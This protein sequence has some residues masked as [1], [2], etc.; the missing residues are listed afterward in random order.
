MGAPGSNKTM[1]RLFRLLAVILLS[2]LLLSA[3]LNRGS[4]TGTVTDN[5][6]AVIPNVKLTIRN[7]AT[8]AVY[9]AAANE[10]GQYNAPNLP[11]GTYTV[12]FEAPS[13]KK[14]E[15]NDVE[16][17]VTQVLRVDATM[18]VGAVT[19][20]VSISAETPRLQTD[21]PEVGTSLT[22]KQLLDLPLTFAGARIAENF[23]YL[24]TPGVSGNTWTSN[25]N[26]S[27]SFS[28]ESLLD[29]ATVTTYLAGHFS[30]SS[31]SVE[32]LQ[33]MKI[34]TSGMSAEFGR[35][36]AGV[37]NYVM[38]SG[39]N[40]IH[41][42]AYG[43]LRNEALNANTAVNKFNNRPRGLD[44]RQNYAFSGGAPIYIPKIYNGTNKTFFYT[45]F[46][47]YRE[48]IGGFGSPSTTA[49]Q[50]E[51]LDGDFSRLLGP[52]IGQT[53]ALGRPVL[54]GAIYD[55]LTF[56][57]LDNGRWIGDMFPGNRIPTTRF[58]QVSQRLNTLL[59]S[60]YL[61]TVRNPDGTIPL[62][63]N[64]VRPA[65]NTPEFDQ[66]QFSTKIDQN[67]S[68]TQKLS[69]SFSYNKR[70]RLLLDQTRLW[71][72]D[73]PFGGVLTS[74]RRQTIKS[75]LVRLSH[76]WNVTQRLLNTFTV[77]YNRMAN[78][79]IG[80]Y[81]D[82]NGA[83][84][85]GI[86]NL[87]T[88]GFP[89]IDWSGGPFVGLTNIGDPQNDFQVYI[90]FGLINTVSFSKG[91]H[92]MK[93]GV[94]LRRN[95][96][97]TRPTQGGGFTFAARG[98]AIP[99]ETFSGNQTGYAFA[100]YLLGI[101]DSA[102]LSDPVGLGGR[103]VYGGLFFQDD[104]KVSSRLTLNLG[105]RWE[106][107]PPFTE[108]ADRLS[109]WNPN[110][111]D[112]ATG[113]LGAYDFAGNCSVCTGKNYFGVKSYRDFGPR[114][115][116]AYR[117]M[118][119]WTLRGAY[120]I[121]YEGDLFNGFSGTPLGKA[122]SVQAGGAYALLPDS[123]TPWAG[124]FNWDN[125]FPTRSY[126]PPSY[127]VSYGD[128]NR[129]G[130]IDPNYGRSPYTQQWNFNIQRE[131]VRNLVLDVG[132]VGNKATGIRAGQLALINQL[133]PK[134][135]QQF[136]RNL[137]NAIRS[138]EDAAANGVPYPYPGYQGT[139]AG[140]LRPYPQLP[141][142]QTVQNYGAPLGF[143]TYHSLQVTVNRQFA[144]G[145]TAYTN[146][147]WSKNLTNVQSSQVND[148]PGRPLD[149]YNLKLEKALSDDDQPHLF[150]AYISYD[151]PVGHGKWLLGNSPR[152]VN[153]ILGGWSISGIFNYFSGT[154]LGFTGSSPLSGGWNGAVNRANVSPGNLRNPN[155]DKDAFQ[156]SPV[157][158]P[159]NTFLNTALF[160]DPAPL[161][162]GNAA[163]R[164]GQLR[165]FA[166]RN[167]DFGLQKNTKLGERF[168]FQL[169]AEF[170]NAFNR[171][172]LGGIQT[173]VTNP[174]FG[175][176]T[177]ISGNRQIQLGTRLDF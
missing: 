152:V 64:A 76:D 80:N 132:Y 177:S 145:L 131:L 72:P 50:P 119:R 23:A 68:L 66:Y 63:N 99:N 81:Q 60:G 135:L 113:R 77:Y 79:N 174:Q 114:I 166:R 58:S 30:E 73:D 10:S 116:F 39:A 157:T 148:N 52:A 150:K 59:R 4:I 83:Q 36:Q 85:L 139:V 89:N 102:S 33:E 53:D 170:L 158:S 18:E 1:L 15:R 111:V 71:N 106:Y 109:S 136:G 169:R 123:V 159:S 144:K 27:T 122:T 25:I 40:Q 65:A 164:Y 143:S 154:P 70:P 173:T 107:Q 19:E 24:V 117:L 104:F 153:A 12:T 29:G 126:L 140:A 84:E 163:F 128:K 78:P 127:D 82:I 32:A 121:M 134:Y 16:L 110:K 138:P 2:A 101:V 155:F 124:I 93:A 146:Y 67:I 57:Q 98:T 47:R 130:M 176:V 151:L 88:Y 48:R 147:T 38:K 165:N 26:G 22:N 108:V 14:V 28:K 137:N 9:E 90:G 141:G 162:L 11:T 96:L 54:R 86:K 7:K 115:G 56:R 21:S 17:G 31:V 168:R 46:E 61:P 94:D 103:R 120:G 69:G 105:L 37:F 45:T 92:F 75:E 149:Y 44:R 161:T 8:G 97:N 49:P 51:W 13:F 133:D 87:S 156:I 100:S 55:P 42:S 6:G 167:E 125:G 172:T 34:Q 160:S 118:E 3:Q 5:S 41:G 129:P 74:A 112:P 91:R 95:H 142:T 62:T 171:S 20:S 43:A 35:A 175:Q